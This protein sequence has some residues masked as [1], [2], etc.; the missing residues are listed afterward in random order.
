MIHLKRVTFV[1][2]SLY[3]HYTGGMEV[4]YHYLI[5]SV[6]QQFRVEVYT[7]KHVDLGPNVVIRLRRR[8]VLCNHSFGLGT[9]LFVVK[10]IISL[11]LSKDKPDLV[12]IP[13]TSNAK[14]IAAVLSRSLRIL[15]IPFTVAVHGG[16]LKP[17]SPEWMYA[18]L[19]RYASTIIAV[20]EP[21]KIEYVRR[22]ARPVELILPLIP[23]RE[24]KETK[25][26]VRSNMGLTGETSIILFLGSLKPIKGIR[27]LIMALHQIK[28]TQDKEM[29]FLCL[30]VGDGPQR[31]EMENLCDE[32]GISDSVVFTGQVPYE[33]VGVYYRAADIFVITSKYEGTS[34]SL[35]GALHYGLPV[36]GA[37]VTGINNIIEDNESGLLFKYEDYLELSEK[38][39]SLIIN[40]PLRNRLVRVSK[41]L[42]S[43]DYS[44]EKTV[45][46]FGRCFNKSMLYE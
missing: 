33:S 40:E 32:Y 13:F 46:D 29:Q 28:L 5:Q 3:P 30:I 39:W 4:F 27:T 21:I 12:H 18:P 14:E 17:W 45:D 19:F 6:A 1:T 34:K 25:A 31:V 8:S 7:T 36:I 37:D 38:I 26:E 41:E 22:T 16:A 15:K 2:P 24:I 9:Y 44:Y 43:S 11:F 42:A 10:V 35:I 23:F 20:S